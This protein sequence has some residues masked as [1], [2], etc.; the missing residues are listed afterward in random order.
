MFL[1]VH[2]RPTS[3]S[4]SLESGW[5]Q[6]RHASLQDDVRDGA[7]PNPATIA[8]AWLPTCSSG[9]GVQRKRGTE[10]HWTALKP[11]WRDQLPLSRSS[12]GKVSGPERQLCPPTGSFSPRVDV[13]VGRSCSCLRLCIASQARDCLM[14][15]SPSLTT[16]GLH[17]GI[18]SRRWGS[19]GLAD[20]S[21]NQQTNHVGRRVC[22][23]S[24]SRAMWP[25]FA[26]P[27]R[28]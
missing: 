19:C 23:D 24:Q 10:G 20:A 26:S 13:P 3:S 15:G 28:G 9:P 18:G 14:S 11:E 12:Q 16:H 25:L 17:W 2:S 21:V 22:T 4:H 1:Q 7:L 8:R 6:A 5:S 27:L